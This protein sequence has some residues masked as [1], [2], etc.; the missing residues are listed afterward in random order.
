MQFWKLAVPLLATTLCFAAQSDRITT[1]ID[2]SQT[3]TL[4]GHVSR[5]AKP[6]YDQGPVAPSF[7]LNHVTLLTLPTPSQQQALRLLVAEQQ[8]PKSPNYHKWL[9]PDQYADRFGLSQNDVAKISAWLTSQGFTVV[10]LARGRN[11]IVFSGTTAQVENA[12]RTQIHRYKV[13]G[14][15]HFAPATMPSVPAAL[16]GIAT[17]LRG[18]DDFL[19]KPM[20]VRKA[21]PQ[22]QKARPDYYDNSFNPPDFLAPGD[23]ATIY[24]LH[25]LYT[26]GFDGTGQKLVI[27]GQT[28]VYLADLNAF[29][30][31]FGLPLLSGCTTSAS[32]VITACDT[33]NFQ[34][35]LNG[36]DPGVSTGDL[37]EADLDL[38][39]S[40]ATAPGAK[41]I[42]VNTAPNSGLANGGGVFDSFYFAIDNNLA[43]VI[44]MSYGA[45]EFDDNN[46]PNDEIQLTEANSFGITFMNSSGDSGSASCDPPP[47]GSDPNNLATGGLAVSFPASSPEVTGVGG[48]AITSPNGFSSTYWGTSNGANGGTAQNPPLP[49]T[50]WNDDVELGTADAQGAQLTVQENFG[51]LS[52]GGGAS[53]CSV[54]T[55]D[56]SNCVS[57][58]PQPSWQTVTIPGGQASARFVPDVSLLASVYFPGYVICTPLE[59]LSHDAPYDTETTSSC[60]TGTAADI[61]AAVNGIP[62]GEATT[63]GPSLVGGTSASSPI[64]AGIVAMLNQYLGTSGLGNINP[65]LYTLALTPSTGAFHQVNSGTNVVYC[66]FGQPPT[67]WPVALQCPSAGYFGYD[68]ANAD[69]PTGYNLVTGL[70][71]VDA[72]K[73]AIAWAASDL[74]TGTTTLISTPSTTVNQGASVTFTATVSPASATG[75]V[76]FYNNGVPTALGTGNVSSGRATFTTTTLPGGSNS[77]TA[78]YAGDTGDNASSSLSAAVVNV[79]SDFTFVAG[80]FTPASIPAGQSAV[81]TLTI[82]P[83]SG[84]TQTVN[85]TNSTSSNPG[86]CTAGLPAGALC[87]FSPPSVTLD[88][89]HSQSVT[90]TVSTA[91]NMAL[92]SGAQTITVTAT[93][94]G[95]AGPSHTAQVSLAVTATIETFSLS[96]TSGASTFTVGVGGTIPVGITVNGTNGFIVGTGAGATTALQ[97]TYTCTGT[98]SLPASEIACTISPGNGQPTNATAVTVTLVTTPPTAQLRPP[99]GGKRIFYALLLPGLFGIVFAGSRKRGLHML[100]LIVVLG[101]STLWLGSCGG[102]SSTNT[103]PKN[104]G[105]P[106]QTYTVTVGATTGGASPIT[107]SNVP[108]TFQLVVN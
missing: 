57:G 84:S 35:V 28:D 83:V 45:C 104:P 55:S 7:Q 32:G 64:F 79:T 63:V 80:T 30:T 67:P 40:A 81:A 41:I 85:F 11:W 107:N 88:G 87:S 102:G 98:P 22:S 39:W 25:P 73:L 4:P 103:N 100:S 75:T 92:P 20:Y 77:V 94:S 69:A 15:L 33:T 31:G 99:F 2:S 70:G 50:S 37:I 74:R 21:V 48:T 56:F 1:P 54:Q 23:I 5:N 51:I 68:A 53:N 108:F 18:V 95:T 96:T 3:V 62:V 43:P 105:T 17:G 24:D 26:A 59:E 10:S 93:P 44:S 97:I 86:S 78:T 61:A 91:A 9:T 14:E 58:F 71:S 76:S 49:E 106:K 60:G 34:Y 66:E 19:P 29:R 46:L 12:F 101:F 38:E 72:N 65:T 36:A 89:T 13:N 90:L 8:D 27:V 42:F 6:Q 47:F 52:S 82:A 16:S